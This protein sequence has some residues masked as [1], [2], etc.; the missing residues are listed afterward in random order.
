[1]YKQTLY[2]ISRDH[3]QNRT[4]QKLN[5]SKKFKYGYNPD[6]D[7]VI[8]S[9]DGTLGEIY[10]IQ[11]LRIGIPASPKKI[12]GDDLKKTNQYFRKKDQPQSLKRIKTIYDFKSYPENIKDQYYKY[13]DDEFNYRTDGY[14]FMCNG[15]PVS[16]T[17][18][19]L[20]TKRIV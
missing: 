18:L 10:Q 3:L 12:D 2:T 9:K 4:V 1:M 5:K 7:C 15:E 11:G 16:Y 19:A 13:I 6:L 20:P 17:H 14:W 8:I